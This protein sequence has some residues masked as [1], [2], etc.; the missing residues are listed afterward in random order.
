MRLEVCIVVHLDLLIAGGDN[1][2]VIAFLGII[3]RSRAIGQ[4]WKG[5]LILKG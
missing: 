4:Q 3:G 2:L 5:L 1:A